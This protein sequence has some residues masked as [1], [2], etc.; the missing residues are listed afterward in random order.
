MMEPAVDFSAQMTQSVF[1]IG[2]KASVSAKLPLD[3]ASGVSGEHL[4]IRFNN[5][6]YFAQDDNSTYGTEIDGKEMEKGRP[7]PLLDGA[8][9]T[10]GPKVKIEFRVGG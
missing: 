1:T 4:T 3:S 6:Q 7:Y 9:I 5:G 10:L 8:I 2:R